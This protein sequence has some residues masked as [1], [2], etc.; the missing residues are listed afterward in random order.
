MDEHHRF[1][2]SMRYATRDLAAV[3][4]ASLKETRWFF[5]DGW[6]T[7]LP[8]IPGTGGPV[9]R[10]RKHVVVSVPEVWWWKRGFPLRP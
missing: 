5:I 3:C 10:L 7:V 9:D 8:R 4:K 1:W 6:R 2:R